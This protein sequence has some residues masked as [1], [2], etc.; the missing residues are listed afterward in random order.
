MV[1][2]MVAIDRDT[3]MKTSVLADVCGSYPKKADM[4]KPI[5][6]IKNE[7]LIKRSTVAQF[8]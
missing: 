1:K 6:V 7:V 8:F 5:I 2:V 4:I 3:W